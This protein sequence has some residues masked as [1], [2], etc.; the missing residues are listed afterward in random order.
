MFMSMQINADY[1]KG[2][3]AGAI[4]GSRWF[5]VTDALGHRLGAVRTDSIWREMPTWRSHPLI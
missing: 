4:G 3:P 2:A 5:A 1:H